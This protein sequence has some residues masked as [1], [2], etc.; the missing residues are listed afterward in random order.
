MNFNPNP[1]SGQA[2]N[3]DH[4][5]LPPHISIIHFIMNKVNLSSLSCGVPS[6]YLSIPPMLLTKSIFNS[7]TAEYVTFGAHLFV[8]ISVTFN[9]SDKHPAF[10]SFDLIVGGI[11]DISNFFQN[12][13]IN[14]K[15]KLSFTNIFLA[16]HLARS[17]IQDLLVSSEWKNISISTSNFEVALTTNYIW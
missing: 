4:L 15:I 14:P 13:I 7:G 5:R 8:D 11:T 12:F 10:Y 17:F 2:I 3:T 9:N 16:V 1:G 6:I